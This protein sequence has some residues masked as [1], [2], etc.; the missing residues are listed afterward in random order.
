MKIGIVGGGA[1]GL[2]LAWLLQENHEVWLFEREPR[3]GG[4]ADPVEIDLKGE[5]LLVEAGFA[6]FWDSLFPNF[7]RLLAALSIP[8]QQYEMTLSI[9]EADNSRVHLLP[10]V[11]DGQIIWAA[12]KP[13]QLLDMLRLQ[14]ALHRGEHIVRAGDASV[15][16]RQFVDSLKLSES[17]TQ[18]FLYP[19]LS[20]G[21]CTGRD[22]FENFA[23]LDVLSYAV[24]HKL[25]HRRRL[26]FNRI[27][28]GNSAYIQALTRGAS[29]VR[30]RRNAQVE[31][32]ERAGAGYIIR[33]AAGP[34]CELDHLAI[35]TNASAAR[36]LLNP[37]DGFD[38]RLDQL[39][40][41][42]YFHTEIAIH[43][44][45]RWM[46][47]QRRFWSVLNI[48]IDG[49]RSAATE[50]RPERP[51]V[52]RSW[53]T[54]AD[55]KPELIYAQRTYEHPNPDLAYFRAQKALAEMQGEHNLWLA[56]VHTHGID[57]HES[58]ISSA[59][60]IAQRLDPESANLR[61]LLKT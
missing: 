39:G 46:P 48:R 30:I 34:V 22:D 51:A 15:T 26:L 4:H 18:R 11:H 6:F 44:D 54:H 57:C 59:I 58:A 24:V 55:P 60:S 50:W 27:A 7:N 32:I 19:F 31:R 5:R 2:T 52:F 40:R 23:A 42:R 12:L 10:P 29:R 61:K 3:L 53:V 1:A 56:G 38:R 41:I 16:L 36:G 49:D 21:W 20:A 25:D 28:G 47:R 37:L 45:A 8:V 43:G 17:F 33:D 13:R 9:F 35:A 14:R